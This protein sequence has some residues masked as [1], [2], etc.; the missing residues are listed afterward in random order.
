MLLFMR[1]Q[2]EQLKSLKMTMLTGAP[3][4]PSKGVPSLSIRDSSTAS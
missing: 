3:G 1:V 2:L 4:V